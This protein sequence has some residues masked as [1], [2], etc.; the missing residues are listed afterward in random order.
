MNQLI[1]YHL[2]EVKFNLR[3]QHDFS[4]L[5]QLGHVFTVFAEQ[6]SGNISFGIIIEGKKRFIKYA[7]ARTECYEGQVKDAIQFLKRASKVYQGLKHP[8]LITYIQSIEL[9]HGYAL[10]FDWVE[11]ECLHAHWLYAGE[12]KYKHPNSPFYKYRQLPIEARLVSFQTILDF[13]V[14]AEQQGY[15]AIDL[16]DGSIL[17]DFETNTTKICDIDFYHHGAVINDKGKQF[18]GTTRFKSPEEY[19]LGAV[20]NEQTNVFTLGAMALYFL[21]GGL[22]GT[23]EEWEASE[24]LYAIAKKATEANKENRYATVQQFRDA[25]VSALE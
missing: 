15:I 10:M 9:E 5:K 21:G 18:W 2:G 25:W 7:G 8:S 3:E 24:K 16:Y 19:E 20:I 4:W 13:Q 14:Y 12:R 22:K 23:F 17:Y 11:G 6:D 1:E